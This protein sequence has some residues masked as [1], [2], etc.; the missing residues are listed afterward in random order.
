MKSLALLIALALPCFAGDAPVDLKIGRYQIVSGMVRNPE[1]NKDTPMMIKI[2]TA[3]GKTWHWD[4]ALPN[5]NSP[6]IGGWTESPSDVNSE[7]IKLA[8]KRAV[9][10]AEEPKK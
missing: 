3:T 5:A 7:A 2:D 4:F 10:P 1:T 9:T 8:K 6:L